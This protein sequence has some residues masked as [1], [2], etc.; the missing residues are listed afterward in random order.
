M[1]NSINDRSLSSL[2]H[3]VNIGL[4]LI[5]HTSLS[6]IDFAIFAIFLDIVLSLIIILKMTNP[7]TEFY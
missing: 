4:S 2:D 3:V 7:S 6:T 5:D 1:S